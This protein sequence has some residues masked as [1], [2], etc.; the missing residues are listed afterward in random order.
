MWLPRTKKIKSYLTQFQA[1]S[2]GICS[3]GCF[4]TK[5]EQSFPDTCVIPRV[6]PGSYSGMARL[7]RVQI[8]DIKAWQ[9]LIDISEWRAHPCSWN[10]CPRHLPLSCFRIW[11][12]GN[13][14]SPH[15]AQGHTTASGCDKHCRFWTFS[16]VSSCLMA[17]NW[18]VQITWDVIETRAIDVITSLIV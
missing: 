12:T 1:V 14:A 10:P 2:T 18:R 5:T 6:L 16:C 11:A 4:F 9:D 17:G 3:W 8:C 15:R 13:S 7:I